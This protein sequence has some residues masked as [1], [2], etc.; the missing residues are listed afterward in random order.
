MSRPYSSSSSATA[1]FRYFSSGCVPCRPK[2]QGG[3]NTADAAVCRAKRPIWPSRTRTTNTLSSS[4]TGRNICSLSRPEVLEVFLYG[5]TRAQEEKEQFEKR[6]EIERLNEELNMLHHH[7]PP[8]PPGEWYRPENTQTLSLPTS[9][10]QP[11]EAIHRNTDHIPTQ[12]GRINNP[13]PPMQD[14]P[15]RLLK[16]HIEVKF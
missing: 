12:S 5:L 9:G 10:N 16:Q 15:G 11:A 4:G 14:L 7:R 1:H 13:Q 6:M 2:T 3:R 8:L